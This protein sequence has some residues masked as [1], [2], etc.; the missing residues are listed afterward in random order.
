MT[1]EQ[2]NIVLQNK[3]VE[4]KIEESFIFAKRP[5]FF[6]KM[7]LENKKKLLALCEAELEAI[8]FYQAEFKRL[9][10]KETENANY[11]EEASAA[12]KAAGDA[13]WAF[14]KAM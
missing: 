12:A 13:K 9:N 11:P 7:T 3:I 1:T 10:P 6:A 8:R 4:S 14:L 2:P 5:G